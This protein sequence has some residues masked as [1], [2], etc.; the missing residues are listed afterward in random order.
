MRL[1]I[2]NF[3]PSWAPPRQVFG[4]RLPAH[5]RA[6]L[7]R[8][9]KQIQIVSLTLRICSY[10][11]HAFREVSLD[12][13]VKTWMDWEALFQLLL[14]QGRIWGEYLYSYLN[15]QRAKIPSQGPTMV[16]KN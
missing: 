10:I 9:S 6:L 12:Y 4:S 3:Q 16:L 5:G 13:R 15:H 2:G 8:A 1:I 7:I 14:T 11:V